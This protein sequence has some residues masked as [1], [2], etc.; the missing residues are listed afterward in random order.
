MIPTPSPSTQPPSTGSPSVKN[1][2]RTGVYVGVAVAILVAIVMAVS[3]TVI[4]V[5][6][7]CRNQRKVKQIERNATMYERYILFISRFKYFATVILLLTVHQ[8][9]LPLVTM[10]RIVA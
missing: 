4:I 8:T 2:G 10:V 6:I 7:R 5:V 3:I 1:E 9:M